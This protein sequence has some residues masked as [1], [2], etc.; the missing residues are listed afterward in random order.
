MKLLQTD[1]SGPDTFPSRV[2]TFIRDR[3]DALYDGFATCYGTDL[4][5]PKVL[6]SLKAQLKAGHFYKRL[7]DVFA[8][9]K[10]EYAYIRRAIKDLD[11][12]IKSLPQDEERKD[13]Q[14]ERKSLQGLKRSIDKRSVLEHLTN[15]GILPNYAFPETGVT[16]NA[17]IRPNVAKGSDAIPTDRQYEIVRSSK[18]AIRELAPDN[19]F[20][21]QGHR[22]AVTGLNTYDWREPGI[23]QEKR[24]CSACD[25]IANKAGSSE[26]VCPKCGHPSWSSEKNHHTF[27]KLTGVK[28][29]DYRDKSTLDDSKDE[30]DAGRYRISRHLSFNRNAFVGAWGMKEIPFGIE[31]VKGVHMMEVNL[32][33]SSSV[34]AAKLTI[35][36]HEDVPTHGFITCKTCGKSNAKSAGGSSYSAHFGFCRHREKTYEGKA[37]DVFEQVYLFRELT[38]EALKILLPV[39]EFESEATVNMFKAGLELGLK[40]YYDGNPQHLGITDYSEHNEKTGRFDRYLVLY[41]GIPGGTGYLEKLFSPEQF[42]QVIRGAY[43]GIR[44][45][46]CKAKGA[47]GCYRC[48]YTYSNQAI[49]DE[50]SR[51]RAEE[52]FKRIVDKSEAWERFTTGL[53]TLTS[54]GNIEESE[55]EERFI[56]SLSQFTAKGKGSG[57]RWE[58]FLEDG[59]KNYKLRLVNGDTVYSY[60]VRPQY[61][62]GPPDGVA[63]NTRADFYISL[64]AV[65]KDNV[66]VGSTI[67]EAFKPDCYLL[68]WIYLSCYP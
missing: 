12:A 53:G 39:Q 26:P 66:T 13:L 35:N 7:Q 47:D 9:L 5:D 22:F 45:C 21:S 52:L 34:D 32:G 27:V 54:S 17:L 55:L 24:F 41:D 44:D 43:E 8:K 6:E 33:L 63:H 38:T 62:L 68:G 36:Q 30:R 15:V 20:Y 46:T 40:K 31:Y 10:E 19:F 60:V 25:H 58:G 67:L 14:R 4:E 29:V 48:I 23:L 28:S 16:L 18:T 49:R 50:L 37:N 2:I 64:T 3:E 56:R 65:E 42:T 1:L 11:E 61:E 59:V 57:W 51:T